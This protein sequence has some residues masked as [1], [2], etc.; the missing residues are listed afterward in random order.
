MHIQFEALM[1]SVF[2]WRD[3]GRHIYAAEVMHDNVYSNRNK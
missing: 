1:F 2:L 3:E